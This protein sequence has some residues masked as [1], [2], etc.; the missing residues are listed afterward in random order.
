MQRIRPRLQDRDLALERISK[1]HGAPRGLLVLY[2]LHRISLK[3]AHGYELLQDIEEKTEGSWRPGPGSLYPLLKRLVRRGY[4]KE[5]TSRR[6]EKSQRIYEITPKGLQKVEE[7]RE[8]FSSAGQKWRAMNRIFMEMIDPKDLSRFFV[9]GTRS[10]FQISREV[11]ETKLQKVPLHEAEF[12]LKE[13]ILNVQRQLEWANEALGR[14]P[15][16]AAVPI[17]REKHAR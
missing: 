10:S 13:Y 16:E 1:I 3:S 11:L 8:V 14:L 9:D 12:I 2:L 5:V 4:I 6:L 15:K 17:S 7:A